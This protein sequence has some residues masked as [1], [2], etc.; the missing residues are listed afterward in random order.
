[1]G[2]VIPSLLESDVPTVVLQTMRA[3]WNGVR[4]SAAR[5]TRSFDVSRLHMSVRHRNRPIPSA[6][7]I[8][9][10]ESAV[11]VARVRAL[12]RESDD[13][14]SETLETLETLDSRVSSSSS[15]TN[16]PVSNTFIISDDVENVW[17]PLLSAAT[18]VSTA[19]GP[20]SWTGSGR[21]CF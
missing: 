7:L 2:L 11:A 6:R 8:F 14:G 20:R 3:P 10:D 1:M 4:A 17:A 21:K 5:Q 16:L 19:V 9:D 13:R 15:H 18:S 12:D